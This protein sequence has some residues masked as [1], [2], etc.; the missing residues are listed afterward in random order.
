MWKLL[1]RFWSSAWN[2]QTQCPC[3]LTCTCSIRAS[4]ILSSCK[5]LVRS[6]G[7]WFNHAESSLEYVASLLAT[8]VAPVVFL[9]FPGCLV[10]CHTT[11]IYPWLIAR[12]LKHVATCGWFWLARDVSCFAPLHLEWI[13]KNL[14]NLR[15]NYSYRYHVLWPPIQ[16]GYFSLWLVY[17]C[18]IL[19]V[20][21]Y[22]TPLSTAAGPGPWV[23]ISIPEQNDLIFLLVPTIECCYDQL[24]AFQI[25]E[26]R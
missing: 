10:P 22:K 9:Y 16:S 11:Q 5:H 7:L 19:L 8:H 13:R 26:M 15:T 20:A 4:C 21:I 12:L 17:T 1:K 6:T 25:L 23:V 3:G 14:D 24:F 18:A 2:P